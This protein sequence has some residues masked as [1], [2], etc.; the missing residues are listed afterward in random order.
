MKK[1]KE[2]VQQQTLH[3]RE[4]VVETLLGRLEAC[5][6]ISLLVSI[7]ERSGKGE[8]NA[9]RTKNTLFSTNI[10][11]LKLC[12]SG[13]Y[14]P[15]ATVRAKAVCVGCFRRHLSQKR[16]KSG[17]KTEKRTNHVREVDGSGMDERDVGQK[18]LSSLQCGPWKKGSMGR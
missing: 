11:L 3:R 15:P 8:E 18:L 16:R 14:A 13:T 10:S 6:P 9:P 4:A 1:T 5:S 7:V 12:P 17:G 2:L